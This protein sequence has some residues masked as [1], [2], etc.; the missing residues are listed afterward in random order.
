MLWRIY[1]FTNKQCSIISDALVS[2]SL[3]SFDDFL[4]KVFFNKN[5]VRKELTVKPWLGYSILQGVS[6]PEIIH[7]YLHKKIQHENKLPL[8]STGIESY[9]TFRIHKGTGP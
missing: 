7:Q 8:I 5:H 2:I 9:R 3:Q 6:K 4:W 1:L